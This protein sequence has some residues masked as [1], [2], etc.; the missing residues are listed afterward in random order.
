MIQCYHI[1]HTWCVVLRTYGMIRPVR[2]IYRLSYCN[3]G[4]VVLRY[5]YSAMY[6]PYRYRV[7]VYRIIL[8]SSPT[9]P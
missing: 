9:R 1:I 2:F 7:P 5:V 6:V 3:Y 8:G 4:T